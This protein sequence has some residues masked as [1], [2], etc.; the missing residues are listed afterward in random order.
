MMTGEGVTTS[1]MGRY[2]V[3]SLHWLPD[4]MIQQFKDSTG[5]KP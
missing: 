5:R 4:L 2:I 3:R 1:D